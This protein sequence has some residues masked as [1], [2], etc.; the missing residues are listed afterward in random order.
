VSDDK[1]TTPPSSGSGGTPAN[2]TTTPCPD[3]CGKDAISNVTKCCGTEIFDEATKANGGKA[4]NIVF[5]TPPSGFEADTN[6]STGTI[7]LS[8]SL[9]GS[10]N[11]CKTTEIVFFELANLAAKSKFEA[12]HADAVAGN[13]S[14]EDYTRANERV[15]YENMKKAIAAVDKCKKKWGC[16]SH[17]WRFDGYR[18]AKDFDD[19]Y[20]NYR[21]NDSHKE[22]FRTFWDRNFKAAYEA[23]HPPPPK[24]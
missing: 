11:K 1:K 23:K 14:R 24:P 15:E 19:Y 18:P 6:T 12:I 8:N 5:G 13:L 4:P 22:H 17:P 3:P 16:E 2:C 10:S 21:G 7:T 9:S 20:N